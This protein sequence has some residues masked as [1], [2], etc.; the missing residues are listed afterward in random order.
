MKVPRSPSRN[1]NDTH[2][3]WRRRRRRRLSH[4]GTQG[5]TP[6]ASHPRTLQGLLSLDFITGIPHSAIPSPTHPSF[7]E[8]QSSH[9]QPHPPPRFHGKI[10]LNKTQANTGEGRPASWKLGF[11]GFS[12]KQSTCPWP[13]A[14]SHRPIC[15][16]SV[17]RPEALQVSI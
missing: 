10:W 8:L 5:P 6:C 11:Q 7:Q 16:W 3:Q 1:N 12:E 4:L 15:V 17:Q 13:R 2:L 14:L 9:H